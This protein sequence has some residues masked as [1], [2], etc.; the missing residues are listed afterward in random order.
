MRRNILILTTMVMALAVG[1]SVAEKAAETTALGGYCP[2]AY[3]AM[4]KAVKG[5]PAISAEYG[6]EHYVF[7][8]AD[9]KKMFETDPSKYHVAYDGYCATAMSMGKRIDSDP[10][11]FT[12]EG[13]TTYL[14]SSEE[15]QKMFKADAIAM[16][17]DHWA[18]LHPAYG[19]YCPVAYIEAKKPVEGNPDISKDYEGTHIVFANAM[20]KEMFEAHP[21]NYQ[22]AY[23]GY[24]ATA[25]SM[26]KRFESDPTQFSVVDG[27]TYLF[28]SA[29]A[30]E[31]FDADPAK[32]VGMA[33]K[34][35]AQL[36][37]LN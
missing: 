12:L 34:Q 18:L 27:K 37:S 23:E 16:A 8:N 36:A 19:G 15:A 14:F 10:T 33:D 4:E 22:V 32:V 28:S 6:G 35:W 9:A 30:K 3:V 5:N 31:M 7:A 25:V 1:V 13:G 24:C 26:G 11:L 21:E 17:D 29:K 2:V 20:A